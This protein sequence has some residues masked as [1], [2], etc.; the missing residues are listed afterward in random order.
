MWLEHPS[1]KANISFWWNTTVRGKWEDYCFMGN[2]RA[3][4]GN[5]RVWNREVFENVNTRKKEITAGIEDTMSWSWKILW[6]VLWKGERNVL[7]G[8][9]A[10]LIRKESISWGQKVKVKWSREGECNGLVEKGIRTILTL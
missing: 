7:K 3:L 2:L 1:F 6:I 8:E 4:K 10:D 9:F 5:C